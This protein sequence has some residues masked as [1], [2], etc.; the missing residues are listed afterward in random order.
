M[1]L[2]EGSGLFT[3]FAGSVATGAGINKTLAIIGVKSGS[4]RWRIV[5]GGFGRRFPVGN[6]S[7]PHI[8]ND[9]GGLES[10][11]HISQSPSHSEL[12]RS[13]DVLSFVAAITRTTTSGYSTDLTV[14]LLP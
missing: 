4:D 2:S 5:D 8:R 9:V 11:P 3:I 10:K 13:G 6:G 12:G 1:R 14:N 7:W